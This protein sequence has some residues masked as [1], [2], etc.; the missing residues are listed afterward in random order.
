MTKLTNNKFRQVWSLRLTI[1]FLSD[2]G[3]MLGC[4][5]LAGVVALRHFR[6]PE[7]DVEGEEVTVVSTLKAYL[8]EYPNSYS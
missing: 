7:V 4:A 3:N 5:C 1:Q 8:P 2:G 6:K